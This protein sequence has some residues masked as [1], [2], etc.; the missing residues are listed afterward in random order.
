MLLG[1]TFKYMRDIEPPV[2]TMVGQFGAFGM[3]HYNSIFSTRMDGAER[4]AS[5]MTY[6]ELSALEARWASEAS[7]EERAHRARAI[8]CCPAP[9]KL[10]LCMYISAER[11]LVA[12]FYRVHVVY[13]VIITSV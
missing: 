9:D 1:R 3:I 12:R 7:A 8:D 4:A 5:C 11:L 10:L 2:I 6:I 13:A